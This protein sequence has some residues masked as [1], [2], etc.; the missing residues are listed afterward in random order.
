MTN[1]EQTFIRMCKCGGASNCVPCLIRMELSRRFGIEGL[2]VLVDGL[3]AV[4]REDLEKEASEKKV[5][6]ASRR[7]PR[8]KERRSAK[9][10]TTK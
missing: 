4:I 5:A 8:P 9:K 6:A 10:S 3:T 7:K 1:V 2:K